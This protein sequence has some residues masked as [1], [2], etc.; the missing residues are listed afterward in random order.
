MPTDCTAAVSYTH[1]LAKEDVIGTFGTLAAVFVGAVIDTEADGG[2]AAVQAMIAGT[3]ITVPA[4]I[5]FIAFNMLTIPCFAAVATAKAE[6]PSKRTFRF[7]LL[8]WIATSYI[9]AAA[10]Y[11]I[12]SWWWTCFILSLIHIF[13]ELKKIAAANGLKARVFAKLECF[14]PAGSAKDRIALFMLNDAEKRGALSRGGTVVEPTSGNTGVGLAT[15][16]Y[17]HL[18]RNP[19]DGETRSGGRRENAVPCQGNRQE[20]RKRAGI[21][22]ADQG[23]RHPRMARHGICEIKR[24]RADFTVCLALLK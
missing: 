14:N 17:T 12:G 1:L 18:Q 7:T 21:S 19:R 5:A 10:I 13:L 11:V 16:S 24:N 8:F 20:N 2:L 3:G 23:E 9:V 22:G 15:V 6:L 4:L